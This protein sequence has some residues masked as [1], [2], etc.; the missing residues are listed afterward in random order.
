MPIRKEGKVSFYTEKELRDIAADL[1]SAVT[2]PVN[3]EIEA[4]HRVLDLSEV[5]KILRDS[6]NIFLS[7]CG[8][9]SIHH[10]C[11]SPMDT[12]LSINV[13][14]DYAEKNP[15]NHPRRVTVEEA[16]YA[17]RWSHAAG[18]IH[19]A[20]VFKGEEK[21]QLVCSC[22]TC[23]CHTLGG[24]LRHGITTQILTSKL[25]AEDDESKCT[26]CGVCAE[27][28]VFGARSMIKG[29]KWFDETRCFGCGL[30]VSTCQTSAIRLAERKKALG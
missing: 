17:L 25:I 5:E 30:C 20:Y 2:L 10:N 19:M 18:L 22:C 13:E 14:A 3:V 21:P 26:N 27:R 16:L 11:D 6:E 23:C 1:T 12:C 29:E 15:A 7:E 24:V 8:C 28:C 9:R 4:E